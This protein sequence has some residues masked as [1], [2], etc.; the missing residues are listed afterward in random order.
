MTVIHHV[1]IACPVCGEI[2]TV[3]LTKAEDGFA[4][5]ACECGATCFVGVQE[6]YEEQF[7]VTTW[8]LP[9]GFRLEAL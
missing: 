6:K 7:L 3:A 2:Q 8:T 5:A 4:E 9:E 1:T